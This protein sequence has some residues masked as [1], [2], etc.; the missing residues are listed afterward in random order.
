MSPRKQPKWN[1][2]KV[3]DVDTLQISVRVFG[4]AVVTYA[5][6]AAFKIIGVQISKYIGQDWSWTVFDWLHTIFTVII[7]VLSFLREMKKLMGRKNKNATK[8]RKK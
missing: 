6:L 7:W 2:R 5:L 3:F 4:A 8:R 1:L